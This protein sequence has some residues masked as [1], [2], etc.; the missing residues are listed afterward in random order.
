MFEWELA[1]QWVLWFIGAHAN[2]QL[3]G[4]FGHGGSIFWNRRRAS[5]SAI[6]EST[7]DN[8]RSR[9]YDGFYH[10]YE[11]KYVIWWQYV[12]ANGFIHNWQ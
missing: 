5:H 11:L 12:W 7:T 10:R 2:D 4:F 8:S 1:E 6:R 9:M 3:H